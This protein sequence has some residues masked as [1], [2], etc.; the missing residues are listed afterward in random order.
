MV[1]NDGRRPLHP[2]FEGLRVTPEL[3]EPDR[4]VEDG[5]GWSQGLAFD[6]PNAA[7]GPF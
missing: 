1:I 6:D 5:T 2:D 7:G 4:G 3:Y